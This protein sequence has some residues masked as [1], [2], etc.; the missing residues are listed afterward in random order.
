MDNYNL[1]AFHIL[2]GER[3]CIESLFPIA[4]KRK[5]LF[6]LTVNTIS[7]NTKVLNTPSFLGNIKITVK[8]PSVIG[9]L[10]NIVI[11]NKRLPQ[12]LI[13]GE[14]GEYSLNENENFITINKILSENPSLKIIFNNEE[15]Y[16][17]YIVIELYLTKIQ[18][19]NK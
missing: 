17:V 8:S 6:A 4:T 12:P 10:T 11:D 15:V 19:R 16:P 2:Y 13:K 5:L 3:Y 7:L 1:E 14:L 9:I 18:L